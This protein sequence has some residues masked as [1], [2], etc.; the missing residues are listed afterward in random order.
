MLSGV[1]FTE[2]GF[3]R[4]LTFCVRLCVFVLVCWGFGALGFGPAGRRASW[5]SSSFAG[6][7]NDACHCSK[8]SIV[9][10][11]CCC[12]CCFT[13]KPLRESA[14]LPSVWRLECT[15]KALKKRVTNNRTQTHIMQILHIFSG[16]PTCTTSSPPLLHSSFPK[17]GS[18]HGASPDQNHC[19]CTHFA[20]GFNCC[21]LAYPCLR[22][23]LTAG[24]IV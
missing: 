21:W 18:S 5:S 3:W 13:E 15:V 2:C 11:C 14:C 12:C 16:Y 19:T 7:S 17:I 10:K 20:F 6:S 23:V 24:F 22:G 1:L 9:M 4:D 8:W